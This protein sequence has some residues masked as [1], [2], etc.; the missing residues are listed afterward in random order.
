MSVLGQRIAAASASIDARVMEIP[1]WGDDNGPLKLYYHP[2]SGADISRVQ[3]KHKD[4]LANPS[5]DAMVEL[6]VIKAIDADGEKLFD[7]EDKAILSRQSAG[8]IATVFGS[9][10]ETVSVEEQEKN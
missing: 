4:F 5:M 1:E 6:I 8:T 3:R 9:I 10:F 7:L 2:I